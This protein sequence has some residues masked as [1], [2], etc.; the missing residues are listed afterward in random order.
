[1]A[2]DPASTTGT[3]LDPDALH[4]EYGIANKHVA[5]STFFDKCATH[6]PADFEQ[7]RRGSS[8]VVL[9]GQR[10]LYEM[11]LIDIQGAVQ[12]PFDVAVQRNVVL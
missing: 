3:S 6:L 7:A 8:G 1:M 2:H 11:G 12:E 4:S 5:L 10:Y 9:D